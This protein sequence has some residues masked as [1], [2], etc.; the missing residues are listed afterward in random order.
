M[1]YFKYDFRRDE[2]YR[3]LT[4]KAQRLASATQHTRDKMLHALRDN[5]TTIKDE[6][7]ESGMQSIT[8]TIETILFPQAIAGLTGLRKL[9]EKDRSRDD[10]TIF[11][12]NAAIG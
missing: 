5:N 2:L 1:K 3:M 4:A 6:E 10:E 9:I 7:L 12:Y 8:S 11:H